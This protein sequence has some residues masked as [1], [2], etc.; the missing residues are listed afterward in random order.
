MEENH[1]FNVDHLL[2]KEVFLD[3]LL[4]SCGCDD[5]YEECKLNHERGS[6]GDFS[7]QLRDIVLRVGKEIE[8]IIPRCLVSE[9]LLIR[10]SP[11]GCH[12]VE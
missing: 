1:V 11:D 10:E 7:K 9:D 3:E 8:A 2:I 5:Q 6:R 12:T 4:Q